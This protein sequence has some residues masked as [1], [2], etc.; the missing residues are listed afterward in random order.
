MSQQGPD[1]KMLHQ[2]GVGSPWCDWLE[3]EMMPTEL[4]DFPFHTVVER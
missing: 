1:F 4:T 2:N 3:K